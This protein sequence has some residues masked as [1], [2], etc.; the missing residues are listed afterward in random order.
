MKVTVPASRSRRPTGA[1]PI[2]TV[3]PAGV[4][5][6]RAAVKSPPSTS[7]TSSGQATLTAPNLSVHESARQPLTNF[8]VNAWLRDVI[9]V[10]VIDD[11]GAAAV[12]LDPVRARLLAALAEPGSAATL[13]VKTGLT[14]QKVNY[15][16]RA[17]EAHGLVRRS[18]SATG[19]A[20]ASGCSSPPPRPTSCR[21]SAGRGGHD[22]E[23]ARTG[24]RPAT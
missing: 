19:A 2:T 9:D 21:R 6:A 4:T 1:T 12:A 3:P 5:Y 13:A 18:R 14:R 16:L 10:E 8:L 22:P 20:S 7:S 11:P 15:H 24:F 17:L 23:R